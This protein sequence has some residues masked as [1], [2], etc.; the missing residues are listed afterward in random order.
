MNTVKNYVENALRNEEQALVLFSKQDIGEDD[1]ERLTSLFYSDFDY[2]YFFL[3][4]NKH[5]ISPLI[6][7]HLINNP[8][9]RDLVKRSHPNLWKQ[10]IAL[11][12]LTR[13]YNQ[14]M[15]MN[16]DKVKSLFSANNIRF[17]VLKGPVL[18][19][20]VYKDYGM[21]IFG[22]LDLLIAPEDMLKAHHALVD[23]GFTVYNFQGERAS[24]D[25]IFDIMQSSHHLLP[26]SDGTMNIELH[27]YGGKYE[28]D[29][30]KI[31]NNSQ[32][33]KLNDDIFLVPNDIDLLIYACAH[34][35]QHRKQASFAVLQGLIIGNNMRQLMDIREI[36]MYLK[37]REMEIRARIEELGCHDIVLEALAITEKFYGKFSDI[38][39]D[40]ALPA[41]LHY[42]FAEN[43]ESHFERRFFTGEEERMKIINKSREYAAIKKAYAC[44]HKDNTEHCHAHEIP[45]VHS[46]CRY[47]KYLLGETKNSFPI[48][49]FNPCFSMS[50]DEDYFYV[51]IQLSGES[52]NEQVIRRIGFQLLFGFQDELPQ[53]VFIQPREFGQLGEYSVF[54][55]HGNYE[56]RTKI[57]VSVQSCLERDLFKISINI[58]WPVLSYEPPE[59]NDELFFDVTIRTAQES[60]YHEEHMISWSTG[61]YFLCPWAEHCDKS[62]MNVIRFVYVPHAVKYTT[63]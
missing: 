58:P 7:Y 57:R 22:D 20:T 25:L 35:V 11:Y 54:L 43:W 41:D 33:I 5:K 40:S 31:Y 26:Y 34:F 55:W 3:T 2:D 10:F 9:I 14:K 60:M 39:P 30:E 16:L 28:I 24:D 50:W 12:D 15:Y 46:Q 48:L 32:V 53:V 6:G 47:L 4:A 13:L 61:K 19:K 27:Q 56:A 36:Y 42:W 21:R 37:G 18:A 51:T 63:S 45:S 8:D 62:V 29:L 17:V 38:Y 59:V 23:H 1:L 49:T 44:F 52:I